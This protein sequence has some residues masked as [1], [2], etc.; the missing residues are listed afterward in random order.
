MFFK[1][2][3]QPPE[4]FFRKGVLKK[5]AILTE[6]HLCWSLFLIKLQARPATLLKRASNTGVS[7][8]VLRHFYNVFHWLVSKPN[9]FSTKFAA[10]RIP[11]INAVWNKQ[12]FS[13]FLVK[14]NSKQIIII[15][16]IL[17]IIIIV[18]FMSNSKIIVIFMSNSS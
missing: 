6:K 15:I 2:Q 9:D 10:A 3:K 14:S 11:K 5:F 12:G 7:L 16:I 8:W 17:I 13:A 1:K 18:I 4:V